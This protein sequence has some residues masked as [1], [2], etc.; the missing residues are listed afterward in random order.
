MMVLLD[1][2]IP[3]D[4]TQ[5]VV[6]ILLG[7]AFTIGSSLLLKL[8]ERSWNQ[9]D[10]IRDQ[11]KPE[12]QQQ[13][14]RMERLIRENDEC[15]R[16]MTEQVRAITEEIRINR[17]EQLAQHRDNIEHAAEGFKELRD[18]LWEMKH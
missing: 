16:G 9:S 6:F 3:E 13:T 15:L 1:G 8:I 5:K 7:A 17:A 14:E 11:A 10:K 12:Q 4:V 2:V 18:R